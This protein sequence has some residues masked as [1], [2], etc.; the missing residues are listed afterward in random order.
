LAANS[1]EKKVIPVTFPPGRES[2]ATRPSFTGS[3]AVK[4][5]MGIVVVAALAASAAGVLIVAI[6][7]TPRK[8]SSA[9]ISGNLKA[10]S[11]NALDG[12]NIRTTSGEVVAGP[13]GPAS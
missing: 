12:A 11:R 4:K 2:V 6:T 3:E 10:S 7:A 5:M 13:I 1:A 9:N 8:I